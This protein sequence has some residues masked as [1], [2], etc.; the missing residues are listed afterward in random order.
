MKLRNSLLPAMALAAVLALVTLTPTADAAGAR[1][2]SGA[3]AGADTPTPPTIDLPNGKPLA[4]GDEIVQSWTVVPGGTRQRT[5]LSYESEAGLTIK[6][7]VSVQNYGNVS[8]NLRIYATDGINTADG[9]FALLPGDQEPTDVGSWIQL[10]QGNVTVPAGQQV[11]VPYTLTVPPGA[12][13]GDHTGGIVASSEVPTTTAD[14]NTV[15]LSRRTGVRL[16]L[17]VQGQLR[18]NLV[19]EDLGVSYRAGMNPVDGKVKVR[20][21]IANRGNVRQSGTYR[22][23]VAG[24]FGTG[25]HRF[26]DRAFPE[27]LPGQSVEIAQEADGVPGLFVASAT[28]V[29]S[30]AA[31]GDVAAAEPTTRTA[32]T[33]A[34]PVLPM[35]VVVL[36]LAALVVLRVIRHRREPDEVAGS[37]SDPL[38]GPGGSD[39]DEREPVLV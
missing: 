5:Y 17:R 9:K 23:E 20:F 6:D 11:T 4:P 35:A 27:L 16:Y 3:T 15:I 25:K 7:T 29:V 26:A 13:P 24:A 18:S 22:V 37:A 14:G 10:A 39:H 2:V 30:P 12:D 31:G 28:V 8:L 36:L 21:R 33:F 1:S 38:D 32:R 19:A 34:P